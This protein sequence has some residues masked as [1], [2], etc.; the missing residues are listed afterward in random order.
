[1]GQVLRKPT[2]EQRRP[3]AGLARRWAGGC[4]GP[5]AGCSSRRE[6][7]VRR[8]RRRLR[9]GQFPVCVYVGREPRPSRRTPRRARREQVVFGGAGV[10]PHSHALQVA[11][12]VTLEAALYPADEQGPR[13]G[14]PNARLRVASRP[15]RCV[16][17][18]PPRPGPQR[19][20]PG[21]MCGDGGRRT[22]C[23]ALDERR[24]RSHT[25]LGVY[26][27]H[28]AHDAVRCRQRIFRAPGRVGAHTHDARTAGHP[29][30]RGTQTDSPKPRGIR[31]SFRVCG[32]TGP[33]GGVCARLAVPRA[34]RPRH[35]N[36]T[37][38]KIGARAGIYCR[39]RQAGG[40]TRPPVLSSFLFAFCSALRF[41]LPLASRCTSE[42]CVY[43]GTAVRAAVSVRC[44]HSWHRAQRMVRR[45]VAR[46]DGGAYVRPPLHPFPALIDTRYAG[47]HDRTHLR[48]P[49]VTA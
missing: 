20:A 38:T 45:A 23:I 1:M 17:H 2:G 42:S 39:A 49:S 25:Q 18:V 14:A 43:A 34:G 47:V 27:R 22:A 29:T 28:R 31:A 10:S 33:R 13:L 12:E 26:A 41:L 32:G 30:P 40:C 44:G 7:R 19:F 21:V 3:R 9:R 4:L 48:V 6:A 11:A 35:A 8:Q 37:K 24:G 46:L 16:S 36:K 15:S 5:I